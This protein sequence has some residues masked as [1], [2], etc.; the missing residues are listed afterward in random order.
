M[1]HFAE[2]LVLV[3][4]GLSHAGGVFLVHAE[5]HR[6][7]EAIPAFL[8]KLG[9]SPGDK[10]RAVVENEGAVEA[11]AELVAAGLARRRAAEVVSRLT[12]VP[13]NELYRRT[14]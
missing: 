6:F 4:E 3:D 7:L 2:V 1:V 14:L 11:V 9:D 5:D 8:E 13:R 12:G 10:L